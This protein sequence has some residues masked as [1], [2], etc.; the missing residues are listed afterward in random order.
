[1]LP[2]QYCTQVVGYDGHLCVASDGQSDWQPVN[3]HPSSLKAGDTVNPTKTYNN[4]TIYVYMTAYVHII[5][6]TG[7]FIL[8]CFYT[9]TCI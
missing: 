1:M 4:E 2:V 5:T 6:I 8:V 3:W 7:T 9:Y